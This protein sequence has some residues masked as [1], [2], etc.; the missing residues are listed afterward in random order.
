[1]LLKEDGKGTSR[2]QDVELLLALP[3]KLKI[4]LSL[5]W[6]VSFS[7]WTAVK[8]LYFWIWFIKQTLRVLSGPPTPFQALMINTK[9]T[10]FIGANGWDHF[11]FQNFC[12]KNKND[13]SPSPPP[14]SSPALLHIHTSIRTT[15]CL[16]LLPGWP[17]HYP[18]WG[19]PSYPATT[20]QG[21]GVLILKKL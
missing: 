8:R 1:M 13:P 11:Y 10:E 18:H 16:L 3:N 5:L 6:S 12:S 19:L 15:C 9:T 4:L 7:L 21:G 2:M 17:D 14:S 20:P